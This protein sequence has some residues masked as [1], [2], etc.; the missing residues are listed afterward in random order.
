MLMK[1]LP[2]KRL[3]KYNAPR[4]REMAASVGGL[5]HVRLRPAMSPI[6]TFRTR[7]VKRVEFGVKADQGP[8]AL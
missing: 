6:A 5:F 1:L 8:D 2:R 7:P 3:G 4:V